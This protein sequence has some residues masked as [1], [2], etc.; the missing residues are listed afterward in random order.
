MDTSKAS[1]YFK[2]MQKLDKLYPYHLH[3]EIGIK[4][5]VIE[6][7]QNHGSEQSRV[8]S[9]RAI[10]NLEIDFYFKFFRIQSP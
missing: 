2:N 9:R 6:I 3:T 5:T 10:G 8:S 4:Q 7:S 1:K